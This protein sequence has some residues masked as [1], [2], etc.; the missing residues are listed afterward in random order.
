MWVGTCSVYGQNLSKATQGRI[1]E[2]ENILVF[3]TFDFYDHETQT[4]PVCEGEI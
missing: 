1:S 4:T 3:A 2:N